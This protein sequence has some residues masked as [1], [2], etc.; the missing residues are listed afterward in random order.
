VESRRSRGHAPRTLELYDVLLSSES[1][2]SAPSTTCSRTAISLPH[3]ANEGLDWDRA[4]AS[5][6][7]VL[8]GIDAKPG[9][10][11]QQSARRTS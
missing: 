4:H 5:F 7:D 8:A 10:A 11:L 1:R 9:Q 2:S 6:V 3:V